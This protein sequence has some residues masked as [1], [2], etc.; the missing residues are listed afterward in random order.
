MEIAGAIFQKRAMWCKAEMGDAKVM[1]FLRTP[2]GRG[3][4]IRGERAFGALVAETFTEAARQ[5]GSSD[6]ARKKILVDGAHHFAKYAATASFSKA[7]QKAL[8]RAGENELPWKLSIGAHNGGYHA[9][10]TDEPRR[11]I[12][13]GAGTTTYHATSTKDLFVKIIETKRNAYIQGNPLHDPQ[14]G[15]QMQ[16]AFTKN[17]AFTLTPNDFRE[18]WISPET[19]IRANLEEPGLEQMKA[20]RGEPDLIA[21]TQA[22]ERLLPADSGS[23]PGKLARLLRQAASDGCAAGHYTLQKL[24]TKINAMIRS[25]GLAQEKQNLLKDEIRR[26]LGEYPAFRQRI[27]AIA[28]SNYHHIAEDNRMH[29][30]HV[31]VGFDPLSGGLRLLKVLKRRDAFVSGPR[32]DVLGLAS[33]F[34]V[35]RT[36]WRW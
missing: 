17:H 18:A 13:C 31:G 4:Q 32:Y 28:G 3:N 15:G 27:E 20:Q 8:R 24:V 9:S 35:S 23:E 36:P 14:Y 6:R 1:L 19:W 34:E 30:I 7:A 16:V 5:I 33:A 22:I 21:L 25:T 26:L 11:M 10:S 29:V 12:V 2:H